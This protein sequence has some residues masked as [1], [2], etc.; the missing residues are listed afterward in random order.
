MSAQCSKADLVDEGAPSQLMTLSRRKTRPHFTGSLL[1]QPPRG[2]L[3][4]PGYGAAGHLA[5]F[6]LCTAMT[7]LSASAQASAMAGFGDVDPG[8]VAKPVS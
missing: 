1:Q 3:G 7:L 8:G 5:G 4:D 6:G 2:S